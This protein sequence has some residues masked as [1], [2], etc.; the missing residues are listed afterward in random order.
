MLHLQKGQQLA[1]YMVR[2]Q[3]VF[4]MFMCMFNSDLPVEFN[5]CLSTG[6]VGGVNQTEWCHQLTMDWCAHH[7]C[8][9]RL[10]IT[11]RVHQVSAFHSDCGVR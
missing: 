3:I 6:C 10:A 1:L 8:S 11:V 9:P 2:M 4:C 5:E 7:C